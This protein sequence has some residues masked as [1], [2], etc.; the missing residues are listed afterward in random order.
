MG[1][2][3]TVNALLKL[4]EQAS[5]RTVDYLIEKLDAVWEKPL[6]EKIQTM[7]YARVEDVRTHAALSEIEI[8]RSTSGFGFIRLYFSFFHGI[9][10]FFLVLFS[11]TLTIGA[12]IALPAREAG[13]FRF[14][15]SPW[16]TVLI[17]L[18]TLGHA[19]FPAF[20]A[21]ER[22]RKATAFTGAWNQSTA[23]GCIGGGR[24]GS[25]R[26]ERI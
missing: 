25:I 21:T 23:N 14:L 24:S 5:G 16:F 3:V 20:A 13:G 2:T 9:R 11:L 15:F 18:A 6:Y 12:F 8:M 4:T 22:Q 19:A 26:W 10:G 17:S 1:I 7:D